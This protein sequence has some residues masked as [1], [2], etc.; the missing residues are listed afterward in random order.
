MFVWFYG[1]S[2]KGT[3]NGQKD[4]QGKATAVATRKHKE[5]F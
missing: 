3:S 5:D 4:R 2:I 1:E